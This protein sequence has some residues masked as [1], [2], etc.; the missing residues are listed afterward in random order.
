MNI[1]PT[2]PLLNSETYNINNPEFEAKLI[3]Q[4]I[5]ASYNYILLRDNIVVSNGI[6]TGYP[7]NLYNYRFNFDNYIKINNQDD[8]EFEIIDE[9]GSLKFEGNNSCTLSLCLDTEDLL[10]I[11]LTSGALVKDAYGEVTLNSTVICDYTFTYKFIDRTDG[12]NIL[13]ETKLFGCSYIPVTIYEGSIT[14]NNGNI[15]TISKGSKDFTVVL[16]KTND[17][18]TTINS[19]GGEINAIVPT[20]CNFNKYY[21]WN[22]NGS[23]DSIT[24]TG[25]DNVVDNIT[26][27]N[28]SI[29]NR[30]IYSDIKIQ[31]QIKQNTGFALSQ[32]QVYGLIESPEVYKLKCET[33]GLY[34]INMMNNSMWG[35][36]GNVT[37]EG[38][39]II[40]NS[41]SAILYTFV[42]VGT[43]KNFTMVLNCDI[44]WTP[45]MLFVKDIDD[46]IIHSELLNNGINTMYFESDYINNILKLEISTPS[47]GE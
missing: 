30:I 1:I 25:T 44:S 23:F 24:C 16:I 8:P 41:D 12:L 14:Y 40:L 34:N 10:F 46:F 3:F 47:E 38:D 2:S 39:T 42:N 18:T 43:N 20:M 37:R 11:N 27:E 29:G 31:K 35:D 13:T 33:D 4:D 28:I 6:L 15:T 19:S 7:T 45:F 22:P 26:K 17:T 21:F 36:S 32:E 9:F 5:E